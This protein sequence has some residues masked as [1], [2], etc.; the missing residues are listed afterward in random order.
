MIVIE[1][2]SVFSVATFECLRCGARHVMQLGERGDIA[3]PPTK[4]D[5]NGC[6]NNIPGS[7]RLIMNESVVVEDDEE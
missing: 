3:L 5:V 6:T 7:F 1:K 4:C 2:E